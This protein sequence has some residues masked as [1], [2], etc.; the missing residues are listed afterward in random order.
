MIEA[1]GYLAA[2][3][4][5]TTQ[6]PQLIK[7]VRTRDVEGLSRNTYVLIVLGSALYIPYALA[8]H[9]VPILITNAWIAA[10]AATI[11]IYIVRYGD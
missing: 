4:V 3:V 6:L 8:I 11:L 2:A 5:A 7:T 9:S 10:V 1:L